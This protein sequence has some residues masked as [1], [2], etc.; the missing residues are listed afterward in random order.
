MMHVIIEEG[1]VDDDFVAHRTDGLRGPA[2]TGRGATRP[3]CAARD[4]RR[5]GRAIRE[6]ALAYRRGEG[7]PSPSG[8]WA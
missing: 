4:L 3:R 6:V 7:A 2:A 1:L 8:A 5:P